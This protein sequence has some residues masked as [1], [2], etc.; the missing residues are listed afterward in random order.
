MCMMVVDTVVLF[1]DRSTAGRVTN[2]T[3][4]EQ[5]WNGIVQQ[6]TTVGD[7]FQRG[8]GTRRMRMLRDP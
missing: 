2:P 3:R 7:R 6:S 4:E 1:V 8:G 5:N